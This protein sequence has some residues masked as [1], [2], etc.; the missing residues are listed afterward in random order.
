MLAGGLTKLMVSQGLQ[1]VG[2]DVDVSAAQKRGLQADAF[3]GR[4]LSPESLEATCRRGGFDVAVIYGPPGGCTDEVYQN[5]C[6]QEGLTEIKASLTAGVGLLCV[7]AAVPQE[8]SASGLKDLIEGC[9]YTCK[10]FKSL[11][12]G[13]VRLIAALH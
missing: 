2:V 3:A 6:T 11:Q 12:Q 9:G 5:W 7:E 4:P 1:A 8:M 13:R 10:S